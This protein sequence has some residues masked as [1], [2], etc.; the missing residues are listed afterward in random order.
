MADDKVRIPPVRWAQRKD[1]LYIKID[2]QE[3]KSPDVKLSPEGKLSFKGTD[4]DGQ[5]YALDM[6]FLHEINVEESKWN[7]WPRYIEF[8]LIKKE[9][10]PH[11]PSLTKDS[12]KPFW[13]KCDWQHWVDEDEEDENEAM[14]DLANFQN[15]DMSAF[16]GGNDDD[17]EDESKDN[18]EGDEDLPPLEEAEPSKE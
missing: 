3:C 7:T 16:A 4:K 14:P 2:V 13:L 17:D 18:E 9:K 6:E 10:G 11:W 8:I 1:K 15:F 5:K 12:K